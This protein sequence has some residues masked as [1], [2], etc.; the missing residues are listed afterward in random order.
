MSK[1]YLRT[2]FV[3]LKKINLFE[4]FFPEFFLYKYEEITL[5]EALFTLILV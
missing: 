2:F 3:I 4:W 1:I 5:N